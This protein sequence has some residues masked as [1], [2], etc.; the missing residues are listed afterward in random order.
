MRDPRLTAH[1]K[2]M[3]TNATEAET[4]L[5]LALRAKRFEDVKFRRQKVIGR[6]IVD[7][8]ARNP[9]LVIELD[10]DSHASQVKYDFERS[11]FLQSQGYDVIRFANNDVMDNLEG[12]LTAIQSR[13]LPPLPTLS[14][15][16]ERAIGA[17]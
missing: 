2:T 10:G 11:A 13:L 3:R 14:P 7:F 17:S 4:R 8:A 12:V 1:A 15:E 9:M 16:R 5:W 6:Y